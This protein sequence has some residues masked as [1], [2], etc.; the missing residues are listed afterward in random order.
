M[1]SCL[2]DADFN[3]FVIKLA[4]PKGFLS[5]FITCVVCPEAPDVPDE[6]KIRDRR[7]TSFSLVDTSANEISQP[8]GSNSVP[9]KNNNFQK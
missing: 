4:A 9:K 5:I 2:E 3:L 1:R 6:D 8:L 7:F